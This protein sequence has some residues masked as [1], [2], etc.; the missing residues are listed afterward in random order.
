MTS[1]LDTLQRRS[2]IL[3][4]FY[5]VALGAGLW[6]TDALFRRGLALE[7]PASTVVFWEHLILCV[8]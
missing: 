4:G 7:L 6:G 3:P 1:F 5:L 8:R 2:D